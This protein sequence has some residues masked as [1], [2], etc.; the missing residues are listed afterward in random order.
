MLGARAG[1]RDRRGRPLL[2]T[3][4]VQARQEVGMPAII[5]RADLHRTLRAPL[6]DDLVRTGI[7]SSAWSPAPPES[8]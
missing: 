7:R 2:V 8:P 3:N 1:L 6:P 5:V 4:A